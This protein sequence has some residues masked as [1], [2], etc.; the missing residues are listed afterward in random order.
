MS[1][2]NTSEE[3]E[4]QAMDLADRIIDQS[5]VAAMRQNP[6]MFFRLYAKAEVVSALEKPGCLRV[7][8]FQRLRNAGINERRI[9]LISD[10]EGKAFEAA[11][12]VRATVPEAKIRCA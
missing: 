7:A 2:E 3:L 6:D 10:V 12:D 1:T 8:F 5:R 11:V 9:F 4:C